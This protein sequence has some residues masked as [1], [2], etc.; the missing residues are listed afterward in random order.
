MPN[1][2]AFSPQKIDPLP[3]YKNCQNKNI[4][5]SNQRLSQQL[6]MSMHVSYECVPETAQMDPE[7]T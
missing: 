1:I 4:I 5:K 6:L 2:R 7:A 3:K